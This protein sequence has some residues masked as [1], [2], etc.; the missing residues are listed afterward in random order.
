MA[1]G[2]PVEGTDAQLPTAG[3]LVRQDAATCALDA[4]AAEVRRGIADSRYGFALVLSEGGVLLGRVRRSALEAL[5][6]QDPIEP[7]LEAGPSTIRPHLSPER[8]RDRLKDKGFRTLV[9]T[10]PDGTLLGVVRRDDIP[11]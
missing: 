1:H 6:D 9:V 4:S 7:I 10:R 8:M 5:A 11:A 3:S 2:L